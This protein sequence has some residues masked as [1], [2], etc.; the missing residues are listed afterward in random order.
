MGEEKIMDIDDKIGNK[1]VVSSDEIEDIKENKEE[2]DKERI[3]RVFY[4]PYSS[5]SSVMA[6][7][8]FVLD[9]SCKDLNTLVIY[10]GDGLYQDLV[11]NY[12]YQDHKLLDIY[13]AHDDQKSNA[14]EYYRAMLYPI[15][16]D[17]NLVNPVST[18]LA[19][20]IWSNRDEICSKISNY[21]RFNIDNLR[22]LCQIRLA[23]EVR[24]IDNH[25]LNEQR[26]DSLEGIVK[27]LRMKLF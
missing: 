21:I 2:L 10:L 13:F 25:Q 16:I 26:E 6:E 9:S 3:G 17:S 20:N 5:L 4:A 24:T 7:E 1:Y 18:L 12:I 19:E 27:S 22:A 23:E 8:Y 15:H 14:E 11:T